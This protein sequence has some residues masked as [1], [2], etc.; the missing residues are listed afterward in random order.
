MPHIKAALLARGEISEST[1]K[2]LIALVDRATPMATT[3]DAT[4]LCG[5]IC[6]RCS[7]RIYHELG[8]A[9][10][11]WNCGQRLEWEVNGD[12]G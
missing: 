5:C 12:E 4:Y 7:E 1:R 3:F 6:P 8:Q 2:S 11:C 10:F 9:K